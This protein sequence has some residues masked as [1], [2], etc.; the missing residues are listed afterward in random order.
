VSPQPPTGSR[1]TSSDK[2]SS[3]KKSSS[4]NKPAISNKSARSTQPTTQP[5]TKPTS[6]STTQ[7]GT[8]PKHPFESSASAGKLRRPPAAHL[9]LG[10]EGEARA[11][12]YLKA[13]GYRIIARNVRAGGVELDLVVRH[14]R[15][16]VFVE[17]KTRRSRR[18]GPPELAVDAGKQARLVTGARAWLREHGRGVERARIDV[19]AWQVEARSGEPDQ[20]R[21]RHFENAFEADEPPRGRRRLW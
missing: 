13:K 20:W 2:S 5:T 8:Q 6:Q 11:E 1:Q 19:V 4:S 21:L 3:S 16:L 7:S 14:R 12:L 18:F 10:A 9:A 17:V 15:T